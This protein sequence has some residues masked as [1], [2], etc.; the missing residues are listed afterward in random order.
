[1]GSC[2]GK[3]NKIIIVN[4]PKNEQIK[5]NRLNSKLDDKNSIS[6]S[7]LDNEL[8]TFFSSINST[9]FSVIHKTY[10]HK[11][12]DN[13]NNDNTFKEILDLI[14]IKKD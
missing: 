13:M 14:D 8:K 4:K 5:K 7:S 11:N 1:M 9:Q 10:E 6:P 2:V 3:T 12:D